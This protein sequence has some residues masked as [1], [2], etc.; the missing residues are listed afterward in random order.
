MSVSW[1]VI[2]FM[3]LER[4]YLKQ[5]RWWEALREVEGA[6]R[7]APGDLHASKRAS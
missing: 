6:V 1:P 7:M 2:P 3:N 4:I 5:R